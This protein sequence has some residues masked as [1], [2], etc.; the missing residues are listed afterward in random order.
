MDPQKVQHKYGSRDGVDS[1]SSKVRHIL[2]WSRD[3]VDT[4]KYITSM[5]LEIDQEMEFELP[6]N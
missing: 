4:Q 2:D 1:P 6:K 5:D 3:G